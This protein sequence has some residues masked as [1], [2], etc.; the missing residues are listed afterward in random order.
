[1]ERVGQSMRLTGPLPVIV[2]NVN[3]LASLTATQ[4]AD[5]I[6]AV[7]TGGGTSTAINNWPTSWLISGGTVAISN[8]QAGSGTVAVSNWPQT[9]AVTGTFW[10]AVQPVNGTISISNL[11]AVQAV[12]GT[13]QANVTFPATQAVAIGAGTVAVSNHP[14]T[15]GTVT[16]IGT[17]AVSNLPPTF[18]TVTAMGT[19]AISSGT[20]GSAAITAGTISTRAPVQQQVCLSWDEI[21]GTAAT[22]GTALATFR[23]ENGVALSSAGTYAVPA[24]KTLKILNVS[25]YTKATSTVNNLSRFRIRQAAPTVGT[26][27]PAIFNRVFGLEL[28]TVAAGAAEANS[29]PTNIDVPGGQAICATFFTAA[30]T[31]TVG[32]SIDG[33]LY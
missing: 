21:P 19:V 17:V 32:L 24:G 20:I 33:Y 30:N 8:L 13:V 28:A 12:S 14:P 29:Y 7:S 6:G 9:T 4:V 11:A 25:C 1:M 18:G 22:E 15:F 23:T 3:D 26:S 5:Q 27:A 31:C 16:T 10:Q 2:Q